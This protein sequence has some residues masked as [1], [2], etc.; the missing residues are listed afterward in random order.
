MLTTL[1][2]PSNPPNV[3]RHEF[4][5]TLQELASSL[6]AA[7]QSNKKPLIVVRMNSPVQR[8]KLISML[9]QICEPRGLIIAELSLSPRLGVQQQIEK[10]LML[11]R[12]KIDAVAANSFDIRIKDDADENRVAALLDTFAKEIDNL[13]VPVVLWLP[14]YLIDIIY[15]KVPSM[16]ELVEGR[17]VEFKSGEDL[18][19]ETE[20]A[21]ADG[22]DP[23]DVHRKRIEVLESQLEDLKSKPGVAP[24][25][26]MQVLQL[27]GKNYFA[28]AQFEKAYEA[29]SE[30]ALRINAETHPLE[31]AGAL[32]QLGVILH[33][34]GRYDKAEIHYHESIKIKRSAGD[35]E[36]L[37]SSMHQLGLLYQDLGDFERA[38]DYYAKSIAYNRTRG[39]T[40]GIANSELNLGLIYEELGLYS[41][42]VEKYR[43][44]FDLFK[45]LANQRGMAMSLSHTGKVYAEKNLHREAIKYFLAAKTI[46]DRI[47]SPY[48]QVV[49]KNLAA[50]E[51][52]LGA[53][54]YQKYTEESRRTVVRKNESTS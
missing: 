32:H 13:S 43:D 26:F 10:E 5:D 54:E 38:M 16:W 51:Q 46:F 53:D 41:K 34:W 44:A 19:K 45:S 31:R 14:S 4:K 28:G 2:T 37:A 15:R 6:R 36:G 42:A 52:A 27:L 48:S 3:I 35:N 9:H 24:G 33:L 39:Y 25:E 30:A 23:A 40:R 1:A 21:A 8:L 49:V 7:V 47:G 12:T 17:I 18:P 20:Y 11:S 22:D 50:I 29:Y